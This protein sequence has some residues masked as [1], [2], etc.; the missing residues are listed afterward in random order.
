MNY[1]FPIINHIDDVLPAIGDDFIVAERGDHTIIDYAVCTDTTFPQV[2]DNHSAIRRECRGLIFDQSGRLI[3]RPL[4]K[5][6]NIN[7]RV[8]TT[9]S[10]IDIGQPHFIYD[11]LDGSM[12]RSFLLDGEV[13]WGTRMGFS[14]QAAQAAKFAEENSRYI[15]FA[16]VMADGGQTPIFEW[17]APYN[18]IVINYSEPS[19]TLLAIREIVTGRYL[20]HEELCCI[21][22]DFDIPIVR[23]HNK[24]NNIA[25]FLD[26]VRNSVGIEG[27]VMAFTNGHRIKFKTEEYVRIA[28]A[29]D[30]VTSERRIVALVLHGGLDDIKSLLPVDDRVQV[31]KIEQEF[32]HIVDILS[33][34]W[35][36]K[37]KEIV[38]LTNNDRKEFA[39]HHAK[40]FSPTETALIFTMWNGGSARDGI[41]RFV[42]K[43]LSADIRFSTFRKDFLH[44]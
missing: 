28:R 9:A 14:Q 20:N 25:S 1:P 15:D 39:L 31:E 23:L 3:S 42:R 17:C 37:F 5:F 12:I 11:K 8:E 32:W 16:K 4:H 27:Y 2:V 38:S 26:D 13:C 41:L 30:T 24:I 34:R 43:C 6:F 19:L 21:A 22:E 36:E 35:S 33:E 44:V 18:R 29:K 7:E 10:N 40:N